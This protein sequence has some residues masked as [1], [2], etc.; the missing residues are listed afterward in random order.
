MTNLEERKSKVP[1]TRKNVSCKFKRSLSVLL[2]ACL[3]GSSWPVSV[4]AQESGKE[5]PA[6][7][8]SNLSLLDEDRFIE[9]PAGQTLAWADTTQAG[10]E[11]SNMLDNNPGTNW[12]AAWGE[13]GNTV[14][15]LELPQTEYV[16][17]FMYSSRQDNNLGGV[18]T[19]YPP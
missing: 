14:L 18:M 11:P 3:L 4:Y 9:Y 10:Y 19:H 16:Y 13:S 15:T 5:T 2:A 8:L 12:E 1:I 6:I 17:G 7:E